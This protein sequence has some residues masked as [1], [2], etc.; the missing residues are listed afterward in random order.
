M[1]K[2]VQSWRNETVLDEFRIQC[3][4]VKKA[5]EVMYYAAT[6][7]IFGTSRDYVEEKLSVTNGKD[8]WDRVTACIEVMYQRIADGKW[9]DDE[10]KKM[11]F[12]WV[13]SFTEY[14]T[15]KEPFPSRKES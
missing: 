12:Y 8:F 10:K 11:E 1:L 2:I 9:S 7:S 4:L 5:R 14:A 15:N 13:E 6:R 3:S